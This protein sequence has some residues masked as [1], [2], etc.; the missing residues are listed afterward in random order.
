MA[1]D[2]I[3]LNLDVASEKLASAQLELVKKVAAEVVD[4]VFL[5]YVEE[6]RICCTGD[7]PFIARNLKDLVNRLGYPC[8]LVDERQIEEDDVFTVVLGRME[9]RTD[10]LE[11]KIESVGSDVMFMSQ[12]TFLEDLLF[13]EFHPYYQGDPRIEDH[14]GLLYLSN[15]GFVWPPAREENYLQSDSQQ[16][17]DELSD[18]SLLKRKYGYSVAKSVPKQKR[19]LALSLAIRDP[20]LGLKKVVYLID[21]NIRLRLKQKPMKNAIARWKSDLDWLKATYYDKSKYQFPWP[22]F[23][24]Y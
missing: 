1:T 14:P 2:N 4:Q 20:E 9:Y 11:S 6:D 21:F 5:G 13:W 18:E 19:R 10:Y 24:Q 3:G 17:S 22:S 8:N 15:I 23:Q 12:E 7:G 16:S